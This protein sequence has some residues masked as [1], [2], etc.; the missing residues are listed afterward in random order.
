[1]ARERS[2]PAFSQI[3]T[4]YD[5]VIYTADGQKY[6]DAVKVTID[7]A[8]LSGNKLNIKFSAAEN[9]DLAGIDV[10]KISPTVL[11]GLYGWETKDYLVGPH[12]RLTDDNGD[13][14]IDSS[15]ARALEY[16][17]G[18]KHPRFTT[19]SAANGKWEVTAD[20]SP[21]ANMIGE[22]RMAG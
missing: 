3:H 15:D 11:V 19:V 22:Q 17:V 10:A 2:A 7:S 13:G 21:W 8:S 4:G 5:K 9:P 12:E 20:L 1:M 6:S 14:K 18:A 16:V